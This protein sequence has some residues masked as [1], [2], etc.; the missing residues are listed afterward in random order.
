MLLRIFEGLCAD[1]SLLVRREA[2][3]QLPALVKGA[4]ETECGSSSDEMPLTA[5]RILREAFGETSVSSRS[6]PL[7]FLAFTALY[8]K[9]KKLVN[10]GFGWLLHGSATA[11]ALLSCHCELFR[12]LFKNLYMFFHSISLCFVS[13]R[14]S[15]GL[16]L[17]TQR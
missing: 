16:R 13:S 4:R 3:E 1:E 5:L 8:Y 9:Y 10:I 7:H 6:L 2:I 14:T 17:P 11:A 12:I 15:C